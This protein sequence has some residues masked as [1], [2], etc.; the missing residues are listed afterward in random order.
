VRLHSAGGLKEVE[1]FP[2]YEWRN[3][4]VSM[5]IP[6]YHKLLFNDHPLGDSTRGT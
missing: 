6:L 5:Y 1:V 4:D 3:K 2:R